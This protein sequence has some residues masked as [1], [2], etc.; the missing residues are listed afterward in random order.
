LVYVHFKSKEDL[1][2]ALIAREM[3]KYG[4]FWLQYIESDPTGGSIGSVYRGV[5]NALKQT[6]FLAA[7]VTEKA[8]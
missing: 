8:P 7:V 3:I 4:N 1:L 2:E 5:L 6:P